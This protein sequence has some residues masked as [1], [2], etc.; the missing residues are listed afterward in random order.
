MK[1][2]LYTNT[3]PLS[4]LKTAQL[5]TICFC[6]FLIG[7]QTHETKTETCTYDQHMQKNLPKSKV[8]NDPLPPSSNRF[9][10]NLNQVPTN[11][12]LPQL[13]YLQWILMFQK[14]VCFPH[15]N[16]FSTTPS[17]KISKMKELQQIYVNSTSNNSE[18]LMIQI[19]CLRSPMAD[20]FTFTRK[21]QH[22]QTRKISGTCS[23]KVSKTVSTS[24]VVVSPD[25]FPP[26]PSTFSAMKTP[27][28]TEKDSHDPEPA[29][30]GDIQLAYS[31]D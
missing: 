13:L 20:I 22:N 2:F 5:V 3:G 10:L 24:T 21:K 28:H 18:I 12:V 15:Q 25:L 31:S 27:E 9:S 8:W 1:Q 19:R 14:T 4:I 30:E 17:S 6:K 11:L 29:D 26:I 7:T 23:K 16:F